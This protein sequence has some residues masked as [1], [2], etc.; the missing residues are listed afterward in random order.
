MGHGDDSIPKKIT[1]QS[2]EYKYLK[3]HERNVIWHFIPKDTDIPANQPVLFAMPVEYGTNQ[4]AEDYALLPEAGSNQ[5]EE[6]SFLTD[7]GSNS[8]EI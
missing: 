2:Q 8:E 6:Y 4:A 3:I 7:I 5:L 1:F